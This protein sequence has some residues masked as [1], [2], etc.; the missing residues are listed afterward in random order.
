MAPS[1]E[2]AREIIDRWSPFNKRESSVACMCDLYP[3]LLRVLVVACAEQYSV[4]FP[5]LGYLDRK[6]FQRVAED[7]MLMRNHDF[8]E[9]AE[10]ICFGFKYMNVSFTL[11]FSSNISLFF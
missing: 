1:L 5:F 2:A 4:P 9:S 8:N 10:L 6:S 7:G 3:T 11:R